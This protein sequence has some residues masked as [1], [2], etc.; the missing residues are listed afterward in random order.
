ML[1]LLRLCAGHALTITNTLFRIPDRFKIT[2]RHPRSKHLSLL[3]Y[4][5]IRQPDRKDVVVTRTVGQITVYWT[6]AWEC[7]SEESLSWVNITCKE[8]SKVASVRISLEFAHF[9]LPPVV[10]DL[11]DLGL[12]LSLEVLISRLGVRSHGPVVQDVLCQWKG[13]SLVRSH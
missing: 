1:L 7:P 6:H 8:V 13:W 4:A 3:N 11:S 10:L 2:W 9:L 12:I 5:K